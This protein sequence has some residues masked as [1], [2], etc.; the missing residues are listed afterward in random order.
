MEHNN[1]TI[2]E[3]LATQKWIATQLLR[4]TVVIY[5][6]F[7]NTGLIVQGKFHY[8][9]FFLIKRNVQIINPMQDF[10]MWKKIDKK[11]FW[12]FFVFCETCSTQVMRQK[13][14]FELPC[15]KLKVTLRSFNIWRHE[16]PLSPRSFSKT[17]TFWV[18]LL[19]ST[20]EISRS[21]FGRG[22]GFP[23]YTNFPSRSSKYDVTHIL[24]FLTPHPSGTHIKTKVPSSHNPYYPRA[25]LH[26][27][28]ILLFCLPFKTV[29]SYVTNILPYNLWGVLC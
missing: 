19:C 6:Y 13:G 22:L 17:N 25:W 23:R 12:S 7:F 1:T 11:W 26:L 10:Q 8:L 18:D 21:E 29:T 27:W 3:V 2:I 15:K 14:T 20:M 9:I 24:M 4:N 5:S 28:T 16:L